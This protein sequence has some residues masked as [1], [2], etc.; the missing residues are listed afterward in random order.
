MDGMN[1]TF[2]QPVAIS[3]GLDPISPDMDGFWSYHFNLAAVFSAR[4]G[5]AKHA[6]TPV[7]ILSN[8]TRGLDCR[9]LAMKTGPPGWWW[10]LEHDWT[11]CPYIWKYIIWKIYL[12]HS[13]YIYIQIKYMIYDILSLKWTN[14]YGRT[15]QVSEMLKFTQ[16]MLYLSS[17]IS[18]GHVIIELDELLIFGV[19]R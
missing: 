3:P 19:G 1:E 17:F 6:F 16:N 2:P 7:A 10:W 15:I 4:F 11:I 18:V 8:Y 12:I 9:S 5:L 14:Y 13:I